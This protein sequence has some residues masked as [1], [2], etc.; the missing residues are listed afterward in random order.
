MALSETAAPWPTLTAQEAQT[1]IAFDRTE[2]RDQSEILHG[3]PP[4]GDALNRR[5][6]VRR[7]AEQVE[8]RVGPIAELRHALA[9]V[10][11]WKTRGR[12]HG[13]WRQC[14]LAPLSGMARSIARSWLLK[15]KKPCAEL[16]RE[17][18]ADVQADIIAQRRFDAAKLV[19]CRAAAEGRITANSDGRTIANVEWE[20]DHV[21]GQRWT[22]LRFSRAEIMA[23][24]ATLEDLANTVLLQ[25]AVERRKMVAEIAEGSNQPECPYTRGDFEQAQ[26]KMP[27]LKAWA[28]WKYGAGLLP[29]RGEILKDHRDAFGIILGISEA[30]LIRQLL[31][32]IAP[33]RVGGAPS[34][35]DT[36]HP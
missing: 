12:R 18:R 1:Q 2:L 29:S 14:P 36:L 35:R 19:L 5:W 24:V 25:Q 32:A 28:K 21:R 16:L 11:W 23:F 3:A 15:H 8:R 27:L 34:H 22:D 4:W 17:I 31:Q 6:G 20:C 30:P 9:R 13:Q 26:D 10:N 7:G 33:G